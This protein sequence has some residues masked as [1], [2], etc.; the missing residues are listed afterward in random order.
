MKLFISLVIVSEAVSTLYT[1]VHSL[2][3]WEPFVAEV[4][5]LVHLPHLG[6]VD[7]NA[8]YNSCITLHYICMRT[9]NGQS[10]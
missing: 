9:R 2:D 8:F 1:Y 6:L 10:S 5:L 3:L 7:F 4:E